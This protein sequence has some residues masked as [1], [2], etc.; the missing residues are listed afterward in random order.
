LSGKEFAYG[1]VIFSAEGLVLLREPTNQH[2]R[3]VWT[4]PKGQQEGDE[5][6]EETAL[7]ETWEEAGV[8]A[9]IV[10][11]I[12]GRFA[13][14]TGVTI[15]FLMRPVGEATQPD[16]KETAR[17]RWVTPEEARN[18]IRKTKTPKGVERDLAVLEAALRH[19]ERLGLLGMRRSMGGS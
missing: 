10:E 17:V 12:P 6:P 8:R 16:E 7:R 2:G 14:T 11:Q 3:Y 18:L 4:F 19:I 9:E 15:Y 1:G 5:T 13:G